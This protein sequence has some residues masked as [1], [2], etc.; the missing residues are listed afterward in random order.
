MFISF[1]FSAGYV[2]SLK[3][4]LFTLS[5]SELKEVFEKYS[6][7]APQPLNTQCVDQ[8]GKDAAEDSKTEN[9]FTFSSK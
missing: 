8:L 3:R 2:D 6:V 7:K 4:L 5:K 9:N 1:W